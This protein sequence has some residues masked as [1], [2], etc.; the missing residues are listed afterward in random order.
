MK[1]ESNS[2][3]YRL[4]IILMIIIISVPIFFNLILWTVEK[5]KNLK[6]NGLTEKEKIELEKEV[7]L[8]IKDSES[9]KLNDKSLN[10]NVF[11]KETH[12]KNCFNVKPEKQKESKILNKKTLL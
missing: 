6:G 9:Q 8:L 5:E 4:L 3:I 10:N 12:N 11:I 2:D 1:K 7:S